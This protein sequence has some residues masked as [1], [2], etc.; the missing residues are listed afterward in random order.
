MMGFMINDR[1]YTKDEISVLKF[2]LV[3]VEIVPEECCS[4]IGVAHQA[5]RLL[6]SESF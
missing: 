3:C 2:V 5:F 6:N 1:N 4:A